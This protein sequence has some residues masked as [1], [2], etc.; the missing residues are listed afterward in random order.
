MASLFGAF[1]LTYLVVLKCWWRCRR[2]ADK[3]DP[4]EMSDCDVGVEDD[5]DEEAATVCTLC[6]RIRDNLE[7]VEI[8]R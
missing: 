2:A 1:A 4:A 5:E 3:S 8:D 7:P 6:T